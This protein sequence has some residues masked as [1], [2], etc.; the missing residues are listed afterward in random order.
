[1]NKVVLIGVGALG[2]SGAGALG[3]FLLK[4]SEITF[5][6][7]YKSALLD[8]GKNSSD[9][10]LWNTKFE[11]LKGKHPVNKK[12]QEAVGKATS[13]PEEAKILHK[14]GCKEIY[15]AS[16]ESGKNYF[17]DFKS[18]CSKTVKEGTAGTWVN[19]E[20]NVTTNWNPTLTNL[21]KY[22]GELHAVFEE[23]KKIITPASF[24]D[25]QR[26][27]LKTLCETIGEELLE[28]NSLRIKNAQAF[29]TKNSG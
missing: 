17:N 21:H 15:E 1:M 11:V 23:L 2:S 19:D 18:Y 9:V 26:E 13:A 12:L 5:S 20:K 6:Q 16:V 3:F 10:N 22:T 4:P 27:K 14:Q 29:C 7:K 24:T 28:D 8:L 25:E